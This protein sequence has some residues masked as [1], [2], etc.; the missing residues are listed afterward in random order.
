[1]YDE[2]KWKVNFSFPMTSRSIALSKKKVFGI[3]CLLIQ[4]VLDFLSSTEPPGP[5][6]NRPIS[7]IKAGHATLRHGK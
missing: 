3:I 6:D 4:C 2:K 7:V 1:M 5:I